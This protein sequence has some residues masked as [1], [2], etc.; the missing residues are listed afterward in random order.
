MSRKRAIFDFDDTIVNTDSFFKLIRHF[1]DSSWLRKAAAIL[2]APLALVLLQF[3]ST[4]GLGVSIPLW[5]G[6]AFR[7]RRKILQMAR[8][9]TN[10]FEAQ[11]HGRLF[12]QGI[13]E[14]RK[15]D[16]EGYEICVV[17]AAPR[18]ISR[19]VLKSRGIYPR[20]FGSRF[21][22]L[23]SGLFQYSRCYG[24]VKLETLAEYGIHQA[25]VGYTDSR[26]D[27][28]L[29]SICERKILVNADER[30]RALA[31]KRF[32]DIEFNRWT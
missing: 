9:F 25:Q 2:L 27:F 14:M 30:L 3:K 17:T 16:A 15:L 29:L 31:F 26:S 10:D 11:R 6:T 28:P 5:I 24:S 8:Q 18:L 20:I 23:G 4:Q 19:E 7:P 12:N 1:L 32:S 21:K 22:F 13:D